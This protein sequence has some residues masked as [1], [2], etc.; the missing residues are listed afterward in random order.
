[1]FIDIKHSISL[2]STDIEA[3]TPNVR[4]SGGGAFKELDESLAPDFH[5]FFHISLLHSENI[6]MCLLCHRYFFRS[7]YIK[8]SEE[9]SLFWQACRLIEELVCI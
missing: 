6:Y 9:Q 3:L 8:I 2:I 1:M 5:S 4:A 7:W